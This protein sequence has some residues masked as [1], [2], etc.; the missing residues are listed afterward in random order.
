MIRAE[1]LREL[2]LRREHHPERA[3]VAAA[4]GLVRTG[5]MLY[6]V[7][8][9]DVHLAEF[10]EAGDEHG[11]LLRILPGQ[12]PEDHAERKR[13]KPDFE[14]LVLLPPREAQ[15]HGALLA[16]PSGS[17]DRRERAAV[18]PLD[19]DG[20]ACEGCNEVSLSPLYEAIRA[21]IP[22]L[23]IEGAAVCGERLYLFQRGNGPDGVNAV[24]VVDLEGVLAA[25]ASGDPVGP[26]LVEELRR[27]EIGE[28]GGVRLGFTD[29]APIGDGRLVYIAA[30]EDT[31]N[32]YDDGP[33]VGAVAGVMT[34]DC[35]ILGHH[36][37]DCPIKIEGVAAEKGDAG[38]ELLLVADADDPGVPSPVMRALLPDGR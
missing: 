3:Y 25:V 38:I 20:R 9:D 28:L 36:E 22:A 29:A 26:Q 34:G 35:E 5:G 8:D 6:V 14:A 11:R 30:A 10:P 23:N 15:P 27:R 7:A 19:R 13:A 24:C 32:T 12:L 37:L 18:V 16:V 2:R 17:T 4:S 33:L 21:E 31:P 1:Q